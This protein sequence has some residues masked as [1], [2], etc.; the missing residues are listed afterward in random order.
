MY[1]T[2]INSKSNQ[3]EAQIADTRA[4]SCGTNCIRGTAIVILAVGILL[5]V[6]DSAQSQVITHH[7]EATIT[8]VSGQPFGLDLSNGQELQGMIV[9][10]TS[11][12]PS[13]DLGFV[14]G[15]IQPP[16]SGMSV[17]VAGVTITNRPDA[18]WQV[19]NDNYGDIFNGFFQIS[20]DGTASPGSMSIYL[21]D[22]TETVFSSTALPLTLNADDFDSRTG[23]LYDPQNGGTVAFSVDRIFQ[24]VMVVIDIKPSSALNSINPRSQGSIPVAILT[25]ETFDATT[26]DASSVLFGV[27]G[28]EASPTHAALEDVNGDGRTDMILHFKTQETE[29]QCGDTSSVLTG[30]TFDGQVI[31]GEDAVRTVGCKR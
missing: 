18:S 10:D 8:Y 2:R 27:L 17:T 22:L 4:S 5:G 24:T 15:Y 23:S 31:E 7:F 21:Q 1:Q 16:P 11:L 19:I 9:Y 28:M 29:L 14:A 26:V 3:L 30:L 20:I 13:Y 6:T 12:P 25:T